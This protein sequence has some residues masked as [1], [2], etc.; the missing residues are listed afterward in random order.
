MVPGNTLLK[1]DN[2]RKKIN[3]KSPV[4][5][6]PCRIKGGENRTVQTGE[7]KK[8]KGSYF[9][10]TVPA[11]LGYEDSTSRQHVTAFPVIKR[12]KHID[13]VQHGSIRLRGC[14]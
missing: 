4:P 10:A 12:M 1:F 3:Y 2:D 11:V 8:G 9:L 7:T 5:L 14:C 13:A 6:K